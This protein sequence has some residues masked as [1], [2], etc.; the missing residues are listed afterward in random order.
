[1]NVNFNNLWLAR[2]FPEGESRIKE[3][4]QANI[5]AIGWKELGNMKGKT[6]DTI[7]SELTAKGCGASN[8]T[9]GVINHFV[10]NMK[11]GDLCI[12]PD[13]DKIYIAQITNDYE[14]NPNK[15]DEG[16]PHQREVKFLNKNTPFDR[17]ELPED[18]Q[19]SLGAQNTIAQLNHRIADFKKFLMKEDYV[20]T[21]N[22]NLRAELEMMVPIAIKN[23]KNDIECDD[24]ERRIKASIE[25]IRLFQNYEEK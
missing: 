6:K 17:S 10:N 16:Y 19:K 1:M 23:I 14:Y 9:V 15:V 12:I 25:V 4:L 18:L 13:H 20:T 8:V 7:A 2:A 22:I 5:I 21:G 11:V 3:F 24:V